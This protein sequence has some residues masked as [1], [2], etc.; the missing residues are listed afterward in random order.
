MIHPRRRYLVSELQLNCRKL[1]RFLTHFRTV[2]YLSHFSH[3]H[4]NAANWIRV[5]VFTIYFNCSRDLLLNWALN[6][7]WA[8]KQAHTAGSEGRATFYA[9]WIYRTISVCCYH[10]HDVTAAD[11]LTFLR[12]QATDAS[13]SYSFFSLFSLLWK[14]FRVCITQIFRVFVEA[15]DNRQERHHQISDSDTKSAL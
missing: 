6:E 13:G 11:Y 5:S 1:V 3:A 14:Q 2:F 4:T 8:A 9:V 10:L 7:Q 15:C 12:S